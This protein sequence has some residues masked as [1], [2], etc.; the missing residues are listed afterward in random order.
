MVE[1]ATNETVKNTIEIRSSH[2]GSCIPVKGADPQVRFLKQTPVV[3]GEGAEEPRAHEH[4]LSEEPDHPGAARA[5]GTVRVG[6]I[7]RCK[8][9]EETTE[10][11]HKA[12]PQHVAHEG[13]E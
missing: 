8:R 12:A 5:H 13:K 10:R 6:R 9:C 4:R 7:H 2:N 1:P 11:Q 3:A